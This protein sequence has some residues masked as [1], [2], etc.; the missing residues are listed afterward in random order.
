MNDI[1]VYLS[2]QR[3]EGSQIERMDFAHTFFV[4][5][6]EQC[7]FC[8]AIVQNSSAW[9]R[10]YKKDLK[11]VSYFLLEILIVHCCVLFLVEEEER[12]K[13][14]EVCERLSY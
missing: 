7:V 14:E 11:L 3:G 5:N 12:G 2:S 6:K 4:L 13:V 8:L 10:N 9:D 1:S